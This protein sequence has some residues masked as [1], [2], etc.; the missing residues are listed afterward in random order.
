MPEV[1]VM[2]CLTF[3]EYKLPPV[4]YTFTLKATFPGD[5]KRLTYKA[6][7]YV[8]FRLLHTLRR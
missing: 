2:S 4:M 6:K 3:H 5:T 8:K 1:Q 7:F